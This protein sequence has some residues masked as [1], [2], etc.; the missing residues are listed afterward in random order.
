M[1]KNPLNFDTQFDKQARSNK[2]QDVAA[3]FNKPV[4]RQNYPRTTVQDYIQTIRFL[5]QFITNYCQS[6]E[7]YIIQFI[8][9]VIS[10]AHICPAEELQFFNS[11]NHLSIVLL[12][13]RL[14]Y[15]QFA[16]KIISAAYCNHKF[17]V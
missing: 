10:D 14:N 7:R 6:P 2:Y 15:N 12:S 16:F 17:Q 3:S 8:Q 1:P 5:Q 9:R 13:I 4:S 11:K